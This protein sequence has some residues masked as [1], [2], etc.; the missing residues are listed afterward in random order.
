MGGTS[1]MEH[2]ELVDGNSWILASSESQGMLASASKIEPIA[3]EKLLL[4]TTK[5]VRGEGACFFVHISPNGDASTI[6]K[7]TVTESLQ[8]ISA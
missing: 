1:K 4:I 8:V 3:Y 2:I 7:S 6:Y 5:L